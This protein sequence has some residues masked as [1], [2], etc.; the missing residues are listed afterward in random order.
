VGD[1]SLELLYAVPDLGWV[2]ATGRPV[3]LP[4][5]RSGREAT[6]IEDR[7]EAIAAI[8]HTRG[9]IEPDL[10]GEALAAGRLRLDAERLQAAT[11]ARVEALRRARRKVVEASD[12]ER[13]RLEHDLHDG[14]QQQLVAV[15][16]TLGVAR[17]RADSAELAAPLAAADTA[18]ERALADLREL[19]HG[20]Y[21]PSL[22]TAGLA[23]AIPTAAERSSLSVAIGALPDGRLPPEIERSAYRIVAEG[24]MLAEQAGAHTARV[25]A[26]TDSTRL[27]LRIEHDGHRQAKPGVELLAD[28]VQALAGSL[29]CSRTATSSLL[30]AEVPC[31]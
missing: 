18:L 17:S 9:A 5:A 1:A 28:R 21:P 24:L 4:D 20:L 15:R 10:L 14:A 25:E 27:T 13:R 7:G 16:F 3:D 29:S 6:I 19:S 2:D 26:S 11:F 30:L 12:E 23:T 8:V 31:A 22:D